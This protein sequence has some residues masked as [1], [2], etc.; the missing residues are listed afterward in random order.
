VFG[1]VV[2]VGPAQ[3][4]VNRG[5]RVVML[6]IV[7]T[8][9][10]IVAATAGTLHA[11]IYKRDPRA[12][13]GWVAVCIFAPFVGP[14]AYYLLGINRVRARAQTMRRSRFTVG[15]ERGGPRRTEPGEWR[16]LKGIGAR[17][18]RFEL[19]RGNRIGVLHNGDHAYPAMLGAIDAAEKRVL[20]AT[21]IFRLDE[22]GNAFADALARAADRN[23]EVAVLVDGIGELYSRR[24]VSRA[25]RKRGIEVARFLPPRLLPPSIHLNLRNHRKVLVADGRT[26]FI[27]GMNISEFN[28]TREGTPRQ[29]TDMHFQLAGSIVVDIERMLCD[30]WYFATGKTLP[31][32]GLAEASAGAECRLIS[33][34]PDEA[35][36]SLALLIQSVI[37]AASERIDIMTPYFVPNRELIGALQTAALKGVRVRIVLPGKNNLFYVHWANRNMLAE[38]LTWGTEIYY[39]PAP[40][41]HSKLLLV[42]SD[43]ALVGSA[44]LDPRSLRLNFE[45]GLEIWSSALAATL[46]AHMDSTVASSRRVQLGELDGRSVPVRIRDSAAALL[47]PYI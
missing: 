14:L 29:V 16:G 24:R 30:D 38:L 45:L 7:L 15:Y 8:L 5:P 12:A 46:R 18:T 17:L 33:D 3:A 22:A 44:N 37:G 4:R 39:Q 36:D 34:G 25:L 1:E 13:T 32:L 10:H 2:I 41:C 35:L 40:F 21:Y 23:V 9:I 27:G 31:P 20:L 28:V 6:A 43:Y 19:R 26:A 11:L 42:D 47:S